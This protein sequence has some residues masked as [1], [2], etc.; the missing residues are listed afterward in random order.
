MNNF[1]NFRLFSLE[2]P[3]VKQQNSNVF[4]KPNL[5]DIILRYETIKISKYFTKCRFS[6]N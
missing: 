3:K 2:L 4:T 5:D 1:V 6:I